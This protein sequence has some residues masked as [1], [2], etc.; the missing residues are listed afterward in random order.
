MAEQFVHKVTLS[1]GKTVLLREMKIKHQNLAAKACGQKAGDNQLLLATLMQQELI[2]I[3]LVSV[4][5]EKVDPKQ[6]ESL[7]EMFTYTEFMQLGK[8]VG[9]L[10]GGD[11]LGESV[12]EIVSI[13]DR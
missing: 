11:E 4:N 9:K 10:M 5:E 7:D 2:K 1:S 3:L 8:V 6:L 12:T 13:G